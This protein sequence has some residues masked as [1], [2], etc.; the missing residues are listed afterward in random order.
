MSLNIPTRAEY[1]AAQGFSGSAIDRPDEPIDE[2]FVRHCNG[3]KSFA[4]GFVNYCKTSNETV[5]TGQLKDHMLS[6]DCPAPIKEAIRYTET[7]TSSLHDLIHKYKLVYDAF[8]NNKVPAEQVVTDKQFAGLVFD[9]MTNYSVV[10]Q[11]ALKAQCDAEYRVETA[12]QVVTL[13]KQG[14]SYDEAIEKLET[15]LND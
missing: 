3:L 9:I 12:K 4:N 11:T 13:A 1:Y 14:S 2:E 7:I 8:A 15:I 5:Y 6:I 10:L